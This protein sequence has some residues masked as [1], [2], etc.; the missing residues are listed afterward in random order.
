MAPIRA[1][2]NFYEQN[3]ALVDQILL[4]GTDKMREIAQRTMREVRHAMGLD[5][6]IAR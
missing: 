3:S 1:R 5:K 2:L 6:A 4:T